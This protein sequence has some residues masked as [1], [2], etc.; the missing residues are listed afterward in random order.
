MSTTGMFVVV[1]G[2]VDNRVA[3]EVVAVASA[4]KELVASESVDGA[5]AS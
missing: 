2:V 4:G 1:S 3:A 5:V